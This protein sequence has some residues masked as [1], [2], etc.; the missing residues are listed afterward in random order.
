MTLWTVAHQAPLSLEFSKQE[1]WVACHSLLQGIFLTQGLNW[2]SCT[3]GGFFTSESPRKLR[4]FLISYY[5]R[6]C[7][8]EYHVVQVVKDLP[9]NAENSSE[10]GQPL[11]WEDPLEKKMA[12]HSSISCW[13][14]PWT[15]EPGCLQSLGSQKVG[16]N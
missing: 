12:T 8:D 15:E 5:C 3:A 13:K 9:A 4:L 14:I 11:G 16:H 7:Y 1:Y 10:A 2:V 6:Q